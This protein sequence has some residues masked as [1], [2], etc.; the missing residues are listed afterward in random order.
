[1]ETA[2]QAVSKA[3]R[4]T[5]LGAAPKISTEELAAPLRAIEQTIRAGLC[6]NGHYLG[7]RPIKLANRRLL[8]DAAAVEALTSGEVAN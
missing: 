7:L 2:P 6:R 5:A 3:S 4:N 8:W 1:M